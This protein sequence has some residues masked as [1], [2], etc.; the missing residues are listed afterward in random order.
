[1]Y[2]SEKGTSAI[3]SACFLVFSLTLRFT[4]VVE[5][6]LRVSASLYYSKFNLLQKKKKKM[7]GL[8]K[9]SVI[10]NLT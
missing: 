6:G 1:M 2:N 3:E 9:N 7:F 5:I 10:I 4:T 8:E